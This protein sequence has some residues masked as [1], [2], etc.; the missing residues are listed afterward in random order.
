MSTNPQIQVDCMSVYQPEPCHGDLHAQQGN[1][2][3]GS[4]YVSPSQA[5]TAKFNGVNFA[6]QIEVPKILLHGTVYKNVMCNFGTQDTV[7]FVL[8][9]ASKT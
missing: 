2:K 1:A 8:Q 9:N 3:A 4:K 7:A 5:W 6:S